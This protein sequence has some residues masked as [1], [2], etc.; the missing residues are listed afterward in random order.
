[1]TVARP[2][3]PG[4]S[5]HLVAGPLAET[6][7][8]PVQPPPAGVPQEVYDAAVARAEAAEGEVAALRIR[9]DIADAELAAVRSQQAAAVEV[10]RRIRRQTWRGLHGTVEPRTA[11]QR[12]R[13][14]T[15]DLLGL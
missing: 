12:I 11:L 14:R 13:R 6:T 9:L 1:M 10:V 15:T 5:D 7:G 8:E 2:L 3:Q 4:E